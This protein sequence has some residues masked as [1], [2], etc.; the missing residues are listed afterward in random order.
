MH[1]YDKIR[2]TVVFKWALRQGTQT[3]IQHASVP[4]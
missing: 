2:F 4:K 1:A 3:A